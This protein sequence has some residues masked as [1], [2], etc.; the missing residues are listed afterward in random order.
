MM[1]DIRRAYFYAQI[2][3]DVYIQLPKEDLD[4]GKGMLG[5]LKL[6]L[7][8]TRDAAKW[9]QETLSCYV[10]SIG[11]VR[12]RGHPSVLWHPERS[13]KTLGHGDD[14]VS[15]GDEASMKWMEQE[16]AKAYEIQT[17]KLGMGKD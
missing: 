12:G 2:Q 15:A 9:W 14:Y 17:Q 13:I 4:Y 5:K 16:L 10:E 8:G 1:N 11:F 7:Y 3:R 6:C